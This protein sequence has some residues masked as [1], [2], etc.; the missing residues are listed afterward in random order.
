MGLLK[1]SR[2]DFKD[3]I[4]ACVEMLSGIKRCM[5]SYALH[6]A[7][8][9]ECSAGQPLSQAATRSSAGQRLPQAGVGMWAPRSLCGQ[10]QPPPFCAQTS[11]AV[12][13]PGTM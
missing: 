3:S 1:P 13:K 11:V 12:Y 6:R 4:E 5:I 2:V 10:A 8:L 7:C 9:W